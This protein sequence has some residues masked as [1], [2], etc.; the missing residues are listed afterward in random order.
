MLDVDAAVHDVTWRWTNKICL[1]GI[2]YH[3][4]QYRRAPKSNSSCVS[5]YHMDRLGNVETHY[6]AIQYYIYGKL[7]NGQ[8]KVFALV[9]CHKGLSVKTQAHAALRGVYP[10]LKHLRLADSQPSGLSIIPAASIISRVI[11][12][13]NQKLPLVDGK[14][15]MYVSPD[16]D[17]RHEFE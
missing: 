11:F 15:P 17:H 7:P 5:F 1:W 14:Q 3:S 6:A 12:I 4:S 2:V 16:V 10:A 13:K 9:K 8:T